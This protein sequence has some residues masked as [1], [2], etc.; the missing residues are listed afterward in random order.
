VTALIDKYL[1]PIVGA[2]HAYALF[3]FAC[4]VSV[5]AAALVVDVSVYRYAL[6]HVPAAAMAAACGFLAGC[7]THY[8]I[9]SRVAF[10]D[11][12]KERGAPQEAQVFGKFVA[13]GVTGLIVTS[14]VVWIVSDVLGHDPLIGKAVAVVFSFASVFTMMRLFVLGS[15]LVRPSHR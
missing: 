15:F 10:S 6:G 9:S 13:A 4:Y 5:S 1:A 3:R 12:L 11:V 8:T 14:F 7:A 2:E